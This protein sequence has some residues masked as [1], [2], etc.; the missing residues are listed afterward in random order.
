MNSL[1]EQTKRPNP[2]FDELADRSK[3]L[4]VELN[5]SDLAN[6][7]HYCRLLAN[8]NEHTNLVSKADPKTLVNDHLLD[9]I[10][11]LPLIRRSTADKDQKSE[12]SQLVDIGSGAGFPGIILAMLEDNLAV[13]L[14]DSIAKKT[15]FLSQSAAELDLGANL[16]VVT[17]RAEELGH[18]RSFRESFDFATA[19]AVGSVQI[20]CE[21]SLP[22][23]KVGGTLLAQ[24]SVKQASLELE[25]AQE[26]IALLG[27]TVSEV[28]TLD[29]AVLGRDHCVVL[30]K[31]TKT[32]P[33]QYPRS[34]AR[35]KK[36]PLV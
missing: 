27:A 35:M 8:Y 2:V 23:L 5:S 31:K 34:A 32:T 15:R 19:R 11:L 6:I 1:P 20:V 25:E 7:E 16:S 30:I 10:A 21:L 9:S 28:V 14:V 4:G 36:E 24:K 17:G 29:S 26:A 22:L 12:K 3:L 18:D 33:R 13:K